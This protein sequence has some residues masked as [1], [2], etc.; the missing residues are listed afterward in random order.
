MK[1]TASVTIADVLNSLGEPVRLRMLRVL[2]QEEL[3]VGEIANIVQLPQSTVS[4]HLKT[5]AECGW[6]ARRSEGPATFY[7][8]VL[9]DLSAA[10]RSL[11]IAV[12]GN[13]GE[14]AECSEDARRLRAVLA[15]RMTDSQSFFGRVSGEWDAMRGELFGGRFTPLALLSMLPQ[16]WTVADVGCGTGNA[17]EVLSPCVS[18][19]I[20]IDRSEPMLDAARRR[21]AGTANVEFRLGESDRLPLADSSVDAC[22]CV[23]V[24]HH[25]EEPMHSLREMRRVLSSERSGGIALVVDMEAHDRDEYR[26]RMGHRHLG[27]SRERIES[28]FIDAG[29]ERPRV[30][31]LPREPDA[32][33]PGLFA[34]VGACVR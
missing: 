7:R 5:L 3:A 21:L 18:H 10:L 15:E 2:E 34:A 30:R 8:L 17:A 20:A 14:E 25:V 19:V 27:F 23:L 26:C 6:L 13:V 22:V 4:R 33:G 24:L 32:R 1:R 29:F 16:S 28:M 12:R 9:D 11:W 31:D